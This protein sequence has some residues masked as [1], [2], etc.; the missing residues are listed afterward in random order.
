MFHSDLN[1]GLTGHAPIKQTYGKI[2][3]IPV[4]K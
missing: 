4:E 2:N 3:W 1:T